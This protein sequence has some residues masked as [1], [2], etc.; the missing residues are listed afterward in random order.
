M[1]LYD[2]AYGDV[3]YDLSNDN[4]TSLRLNLGYIRALAN[5]LDLTSMTPRRR[6]VVERLLPGQ[7]GRFPARHIWSI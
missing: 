2:D 4:D 7:S 5:R 6:V 1:D 3:G